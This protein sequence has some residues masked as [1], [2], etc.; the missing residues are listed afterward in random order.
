MPE[1]IGAHLP[2]NQ[3]RKYEA[4]SGLC[5]TSEQRH[6][7]RRLL[8]IDL[9]MLGCNI[10]ANKEVIIGTN[11]LTGDEKFIPV[12]AFRV[13]KMYYTNEVY[14]GNQVGG[15]A[16]DM[17][18]SYE[19]KSHGQFNTPFNHHHLLKIKRNASDRCKVCHPVIPIVDKNNVAHCKVSAIMKVEEREGDNKVSPLTYVDLLNQ[20]DGRACGLNIK[21]LSLKRQ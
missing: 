14:P 15:L 2:D 6:L 16:P 3:L 11:N 17:M 10:D 8:Y 12:K 19:L 9:G 18:A 21:R 13:R 5:L 20:P 1:Y 7:R 4:E